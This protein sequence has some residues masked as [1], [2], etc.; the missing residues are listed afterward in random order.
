MNLLAGYVDGIAG[1]DQRAAPDG[2]ALLPD[3]R[4]ATGDDVFHQAGI[5]AVSVPERGQ[6]LREQTHRRDAV[7]G[8]VWPP[9]AAGRAHVVK[10]VSFVH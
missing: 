2:A 3:R 5:E 8:A 9:P 1:R 7:Q 6:H 10:N 4:T